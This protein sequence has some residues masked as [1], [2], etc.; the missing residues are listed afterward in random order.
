MIGS[1]VD[2]DRRVGDRREDRMNEGWVKART[3]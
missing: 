3:D 1:R 2:G